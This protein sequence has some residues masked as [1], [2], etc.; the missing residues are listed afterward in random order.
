MIKNL[1]YLACCLASVLLFGCGVKQSTE[2]PLTGMATSKQQSM[3]AF[4]SISVNGPYDVE[5]NVGKSYYNTTLVTVSG[6]SGLTDYTHYFVKNNALT[7]YIDPDYTYNPFVHAKIQV[8]SASANRI[9]LR[10]GATVTVQN[11]NTPHFSIKMDSGSAFLSG[12]ASRFDATLT[13][14]SKLNAKCLQADAIFVNTTGTSQA[15]ILGTAGIS[16]LATGHSNIYYYTT[17]DMTQPYER[18]SGSMMRMDGILPATAPK[19]ITTMYS[20]NYGYK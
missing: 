18:Q 16:G 5:M 8:N 2:L 6:D 14:D 13:G 12:A 19:P 20:A 15:E 9:Y 1:S 7:V 10:G 11:I 3:P 17:P 4:D